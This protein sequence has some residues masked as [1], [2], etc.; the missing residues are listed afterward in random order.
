MLGVGGSCVIYEKSCT[1]EP[2]AGPGKGC[3]VNNTLLRK[4]KST[5]TCC[6]PPVCRHL[7]GFGGD[8]VTWVYAVQYHRVCQGLLTI[9]TWWVPAFAIDLMDTWEDHLQLKICLK[10]R[11]IHFIL[12]CRNSGL[13]VPLVKIVDFNTLWV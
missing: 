3:E 8:P 12:H 7:L 6:A 9:S 1:A 10:L 11:S 5:S 13:K 2:Q 4:A